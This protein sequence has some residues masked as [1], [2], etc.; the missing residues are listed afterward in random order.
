MANGTNRDQSYRVLFLSLAA[1]FFILRA[2]FLLLCNFDLC[3][4]ICSSYVRNQFPVPADLRLS[5]SLGNVFNFSVSFLCHALWRTCGLGIITSL[6]DLPEAYSF[7]RGWCSKLWKVNLWH[8]C[9][10][11][12][13]QSALFDFN[14]PSGR[15]QGI[16]FSSTLHLNDSFIP[17]NL[18]M[19]CH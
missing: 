2:T 6:R 7:S 10:P 19:L 14:V 12:R 15:V 13:S 18:Q 17:R 9:V 5:A 11:K 4:C 3:A 8:S 16:M 1:S